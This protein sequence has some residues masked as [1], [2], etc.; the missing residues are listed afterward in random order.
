MKSRKTTWEVVAAG[1]I[2]MV[3]GVYLIHPPEP[4]ASSPEHTRFKHAEVS[5]LF[6]SYQPSDPNP[7]NIEIHLKSLKNLEQ[8]KKLEGLKE[9]EQVQKELKNLEEELKITLPE[10]AGLSMPALKNLP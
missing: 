7:K 10:P 5:N 9:L 1:C 8:L 4:S 2:F 3:L 6:K